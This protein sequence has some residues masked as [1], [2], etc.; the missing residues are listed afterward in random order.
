MA[1]SIIIDLLMKTGAFETDTKRAEKRLQAF[2]KEAER[3]GKA[4]GAAFLAAG[5]ALAAM[6]AST[7][8]NA[9]EI[10]RLSM[11]SGVGAESFQKYAAGAS[12]L[13]IEQEKLADIFKDTQDKVG[14]FLQTGGGP[15]ADFFENIAPQVGVTAEQFRKLSG[16][17]ALELYVKS[18][19][20]A[21][22][23]QSEMTFFM[24]AIA[25]D[26][27]MLLPLLRDNADGFRLV[28][29]AAA[30]AGGIM[31]DDLLRDVTELQAATFL[32]EQQWTGL[33]TQLAGPVIDVL[34]DVSG[35]LVDSNADTSIATV[36]ANDLAEGMRWAAAAAVGF[37][38]AVSIA[39]KA[40]GGWIDAVEAIDF[41]IGDAFFPGR[42]A[43]KIFNKAGEVNDALS[44]AGADLDETAQAYGK[45]INDIFN[46]PEDGS[47]GRDMIS[48]MADM[49]EKAKELRAALA[50]NGGEDGGTVTAP[51]I[52]EIDTSGLETRRGLLDTMFDP[53]MA[54][55]MLEDLDAVIEGF[56]SADGFVRGTR[57]QVERLEEQIAR[58]R[59]LADQGFFAEGT[60]QE[61][62]ARL[63]ERLDAAKESAMDTGDEISE[64]MRAASERTQGII[65]EGLIDGFDEG[66]SGI[67]DSFTSLID[68]LV[69]EAVAAQIAGKLFG[70]EG[71][72]SGGGWVGQAAGWLGNIFGGQRAAGG[73]VEAGVTYGI[74]EVEPEFF[75]PRGAG[76]VVPLSKAAA[77]GAM[78]TTVNQQIMV[79]G[80]VDQR[81]ASQIAIES[82]RRQRT[83][84]A[85]FG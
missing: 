30:D 40:V 21:N 10:T 16:P 68:Q 13:G 36:L 19:E 44:S 85:R 45:I 4:I 73:G 60:D 18:L 20:D 71:V 50:G 82:A 26:A 43:F 61:V 64:F 38:G 53:A 58:V 8:R 69:A 5:T 35:A 84:T 33:Q 15:L 52:E 76:N 67:L 78:G 49:I 74:N 39:V 51:T 66:A 17:E 47:S 23:S 75:K 54:D 77:E 70:E 24:E 31:G 11:I 83:A 72:G 14:D 57:T 81:T 65:A 56:Q 34:Q 2:K 9:E 7:I 42:A 28:G 80:R 3:V 6:T 1:G 41:D 55:A 25:S 27:T 22:I 59:E 32:L 62:L 29:Q 46:P 79:Q 12:L 63:Q 48:E 37:A